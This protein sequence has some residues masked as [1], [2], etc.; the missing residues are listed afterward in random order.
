[1]VLQN[2]ILSD[3]NHGIITLGQSGGEGG[4]GEERVAAFKPI[5]SKNGRFVHSCPNELFDECSWFITIRQR[6]L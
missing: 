5:K 1:M 6:L 4:E 3:Y 2:N